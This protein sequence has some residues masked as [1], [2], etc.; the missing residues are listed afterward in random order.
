MGIRELVKS[1]DKQVI[2]EISTEWAKRGW[3]GG[4]RTGYRNFRRTFWP[5][6]PSYAG[7]KISYDKTRAL[8]R[9]DDKNANLGSGIVRRIV[10][11]RV[12]FIEL[13]Y[14]ATGDEVFDEFLEKCIHTY[15]AAE[16]QKMIRDSTRDAETVVRIRRHELQ[17]PLISA[18]EWEACFLEIVPP[19]KVSIYYKQG[20]TSGEI[21][22][23]YVRHEIEE[24]IENL[25]QNGRAVTLP[26]VRQK[27]I[28]EEITP[29]AFRYFDQT[30]GRWRNDLE[31][32]NTWGFIPLVEVKNEEESYLEGGQSDLESCL[33][34]IFAFHDVMA[35]SLTAHKAHS[36]P[37]AKFKI[38][39]LMGF[40]ANNWPE[41]FERDENGNIKPET[42]NGKIEWKGTEIL[43]MQSEED[44]DFLQAESV[45]GD[46]KVLMDFLIDCIAMS[47]ETPRF[48]LMN[49]KVDDTDEIE[50]FAKLISR[51]RR[52]YQPF[53]QQMCKMVLAINFME[54][55][56]VPLAWDDVTAD[57]ALV[58]ASALQQ[59]VMADEV[60]ATREVISDRTMR[61]DLKKHIPHMQRNQLEKAEAKNNK[62]LDVI[63]PGSVSGSDSGNNE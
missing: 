41:S 5:T 12:D 54:P 59:R 7:F 13:P 57:E 35:A 53:V 44:A 26:Q 2:G 47:S 32:P 16:L 24:K 55:V 18:E 50:P 40:I 1:D 22:V 60:L 33:P 58:K 51:K 42:F 36:I 23:A 63:S 37:K 4:I 62:Q 46:S 29:D 25:E 15:W 49:T 28:I 11:S 56:L 43:F 3:L 38:N 52:F 39:D 6:A 48:I 27:V 9:S 8:Y 31:Q 10:N 19:E 45:L 17:N 30:E 21:E 61:A 34:F 14:P 20:G